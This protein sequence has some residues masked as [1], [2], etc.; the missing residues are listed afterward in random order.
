M[1][2]GVWASALKPTSAYVNPVSIFC[3]CFFQAIDDDGIERHAALLQF[4]TELL[5]GL[6]KH[7][8]VPVGSGSP[9][10]RIIDARCK[11]VRRRRGRLTPI[12]SRPRSAASSS[13]SAGAPAS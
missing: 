5:H 10:R 13:T 6:K 9:L 2:R 11:I 7:A 12:T 4:Q 1:R 8:E 3:R